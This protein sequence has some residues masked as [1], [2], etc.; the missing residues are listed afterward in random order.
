M[1]SKIFVLSYVLYRDFGVLSFHKSSGDIFHIL[2]YSW[3]FA[4]EKCNWENS[5]NIFK[6]TGKD[7][8]Q[9][10]RI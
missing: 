10:E 4:K 3:F 9:K 1:L 7:T 6:I 2:R 5:R 8:M